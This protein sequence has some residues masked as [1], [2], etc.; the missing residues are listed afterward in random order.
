M[1]LLNR[2]LTIDDRQY[3]FRKASSTSHA[4]W[5]FEEARRQ[6][7]NTSKKGYVIFLDFSKA[8][9]K[10]CRNKM[11]GSLKGFLDPLEWYTL[12][13]YYEIGSVRVYI[14]K[15]AKTSEFFV[16]IV[17]V[18]QGGQL[19]PTAFNKHIDLMI[20]KIDDTGELYTM[21]L[22]NKYF[23]FILI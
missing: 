10:V 18:K 9:D 8:F 3:G 21:P 22:K 13:Q 6:L 4:Y 5:V 15:A 1:N 20:T 17:G 7:A 23:K 19:S 2:K 16:T 14:Q 12:M 11:L